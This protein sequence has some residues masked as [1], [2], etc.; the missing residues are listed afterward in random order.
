MPL[1]YLNCADTTC[2][3][4]VAEDGIGIVSDRWRFADRVGE[5]RGDGTGVSPDMT[6][7]REKKEKPAVSARPVGSSGDVSPKAK[8]FWRGLVRGGYSSS[9]SGQVLSACVVSSV[10]AH[11]Q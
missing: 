4:R 3:D 5:E 11:P 10:R 9:H 8:P 1:L 6:M 2:G 7:Q